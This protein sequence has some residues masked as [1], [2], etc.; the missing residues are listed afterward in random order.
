MRADDLNGKKFGRL[1]GI[2]RVDNVGRQTRWLWQCDCGKETVAS[3]DKVKSGHTRSCGCLWPELCKKHGH[4]HDANGQQTKTYKAWVNM[5]SRV[6]GIT[7]GYKRAYFDRGITVCD[8]WNS[9]ELF[10][11]D[12]GESP[13]GL[14]LERIDN[15]RGYSPDN[16]KWASRREQN[17]N[18]RRTVKVTID[19]EEM[20]L[21]DACAITGVNYQ[22]AIWRI[23]H[24]RTAELA[25]RP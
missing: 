19:S 7:P 20:C 4:G 22:T 24:G 3:A 14:M 9:F 21:R 8:R 1:T 10:L 15:N 23:K 6:A 17:R 25:I 11:A 2:R 13:P 5:R 12:M 16:C 18:T